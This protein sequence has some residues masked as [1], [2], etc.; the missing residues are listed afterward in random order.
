MAGKFD[1]RWNLRQVMASQEMFQ[2]TDLT[3]LL[4]RTRDSPVLQPGLPAGGRVARTA[5]PQGG[6]RSRRD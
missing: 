2:T 3:P 1:Y 6:I 4:G 5:Q